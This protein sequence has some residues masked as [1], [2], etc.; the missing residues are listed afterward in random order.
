MQLQRKF[1]IGT[2]ETI[3]TLEV[4]DLECSICLEKL[5]DGNSLVNNAAAP[6]PSNDPESPSNNVSDAFSIN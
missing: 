5:Q 1:S 6:V 2:S 3:R 4:S